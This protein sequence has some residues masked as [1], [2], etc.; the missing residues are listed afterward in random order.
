MS[1]LLA[2]PVQR[3]LKESGAY[4]PPISPSGKASLFRQALFLNAATP[5][6]CSYGN[7]TISA[8]LIWSL[9]VT[10]RGVKV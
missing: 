6:L 4:A 10:T 2:A 7:A 3:A 9:T 5:P 8:S 1:I